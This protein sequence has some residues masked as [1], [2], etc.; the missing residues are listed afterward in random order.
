[1][2]DIIGMRF[3]DYEVI[4]YM[5]KLNPKR[6]DNYYKIRCCI[7]GEERIVPKTLKAGFSKAK[8]KHCETICINYFRQIEIGKIYGDYTVIEFLGVESNNK[9]YKVKCNICKR[10]K[11]VFLK[12]LKNGKGISHQSCVK[13][14]GGVDKRFYEIWCGMI[15]RTTNKNCASYKDYGGRGINS[16]SYKFFIDFYDDMYESYVKH[17]KEYGE[18]NTSLDRIDVNG[19][20]EKDNLRWATIKVQNRNTRK[21]LETC[22][23]ID[24]KGNKYEFNCVKSFAEEHSLNAT[25]IYNVLNGRQK[26]YKGWIFYRN[27]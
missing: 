20:Y 1:M 10:E 11:E 27:R 13:T 25:Y 3:G 19:N 8:Y 2:E 5:G 26:T 23:A 15:K 18:N 6:T 24:Y 17:C 9:R 7:C 14:L 22:V 12:H 21:Q 4:E 16:D